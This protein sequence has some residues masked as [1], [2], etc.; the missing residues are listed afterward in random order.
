MEWNGMEWNGMEWLALFV[1]RRHERGFPT[2][3]IPSILSTATGV[4]HGG[5]CHLQSDKQAPPPVSLLAFIYLG[6]A[7]TVDY[8]IYPTN[9]HYLKDA[10]F[11][12]LMKV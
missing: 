9:V 4:P 2:R 12:M 5:C 1:N 8:Y 6:R 3:R 10:T 7:K 11:F